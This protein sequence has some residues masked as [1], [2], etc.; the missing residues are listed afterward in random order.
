MSFRSNGK[1]WYN[2]FYESLFPA[3]Y[4]VHDDEVG[5]KFSLKAV[6]DVK[7]SMDFFMLLSD[8]TWFIGQPHRS[9]SK[10]IYSFH[11]PL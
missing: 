11:T 4:L 8:T 7:K 2:N 9:P 10:P 5:Y 6:M 3:T 1:S